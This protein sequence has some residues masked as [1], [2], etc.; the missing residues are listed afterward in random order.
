[1]AATSSDLLDEE[2][3]LLSEGKLRPTSVETPITAAHTAVAFSHPESQRGTALLLCVEQTALNLAVIHEGNLLVVRN[4]PLL[5]SGESDPESIAH[6]VTDVLTREIEITWRKLFD[7]DPDA[8]LRVYLVSESRIA[9]YLAAAIETDANCRVTLVD[10]YAGMR[11]TPS[12][13]G[14]FP[15]CVAE[16]LALRKLLPEQAGAVNFL[17]PHNTRDRSLLSTKKELMVCG[18]LLAT[19][20]LVW[21]AG[22]F[23]QLARLESQR[24]KIKEQINEVFRQALPEELNIVNPQ[25]QLQQKLD[26]FDS[27]TA[28]LTP[29]RRGRLTPLEILRLLST[30][31]PTEGDLR[32]DDLL[33]AT[34]SVRVTGRCD[35][36]TTFSEWQRVL[37]TIPGFHT[38]D[39]PKQE[40]DAKTGKVH[41]TLSLSSGKAVQ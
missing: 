34:D 2:L 21:I 36:F 37:E 39:V 18:G 3:S 22:L 11:D 24:I 31:Q 28:M 41:F 12:D 8:D 33:V 30:H 25:A 17:L 7:A 35:S 6:Q 13:D 15:L 14:R 26:S 20:I 38:V 29:F 32:L 19:I 9:R 23:F 27:D 5:R 10:P 16:G 4:I 1:V 40:K